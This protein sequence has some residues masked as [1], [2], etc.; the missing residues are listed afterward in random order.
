SL[1]A[2]I[3]SRRPFTL[4]EQ[5]NFIVEVCDGLTYAHQRSVVHRDIK[6]GNIMVLKDGGVK[7]VDFG[8]AHI[9]NLTATRTGQLLGSL[10]Y[11][12]PEQISGK[13]VD[14]RTDIFSLATVFY[15]LLTLHLPFD[16]ETPAA[17]L[18]KIMQEQPP[19]LAD[20]DKCLPPELDAI[21]MHAF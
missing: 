9:G 5:I 10:P 14:G 16:G 1:D 7:I 2:F 6:P 21:L 11:M 8:I 17:T 19:C 12:S 18:L 20:Y 13:P 15:Q 3:Q 4:L